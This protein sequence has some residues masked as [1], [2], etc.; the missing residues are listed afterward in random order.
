M[1]IAIIT[2]SYPPMRSSGAIQV[3]D[4]AMA[5][6][7]AGHKPFVLFPDHI[8]KESVVLEEQNNIT[9][10][11]IKFPKTR[12]RN[13]LIRAAFELIMPYAMWYRLSFSKFR[14]NSYDAVVCYSPS[15]F[16]APLIGKLKSENNAIC[17]L[18]VRDL[19]PKWSVDLGLIKSGSLIHI[20]LQFVESKLYS[21][22]DIIGVQTESNF[23][24]FKNILI[25]KN[26]TV[27]VLYN[28]LSKSSTSACSINLNKTRLKG[29]KVFIYAGNMGVAQGLE[30]IISLINEF[31]H[32]ESIGF[33]FVGRGA[34]FN[35]IKNQID[36]GELCNAII[37]P[38]ISPEEIP[39]LFQQCYA[40]LICLDKRHT[41][42]NIPGKFLSYM[43]SALPV[44]AAVNPDNDIIKIIEENR[45]GVATDRH[46]IKELA[47]C[48]ES[49]INLI[50]TDS[51]INERCHALFEKKFSSINAATKII[52]SIEKKKITKI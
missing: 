8:V 45:V 19:F 5:L 4:L 28:W 34:L 25:S 40:G 33:L 48:F 24:H 11:R 51:D 32:D 3:Q 13:Y 43:R 41:T 21:A 27:E 15:I 14:D 36:E 22:V 37:Y 1:K 42:D 18:I 9:N 2:A 29:K 20:F 7:C 35:K 26:T 46:D 38:E 31:K 17:Y 12:D 6:A 52:N 23:E 49:L 10:L 44:L 50:D 39:S 30:P 16:F 47:R